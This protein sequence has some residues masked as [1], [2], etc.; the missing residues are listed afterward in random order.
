[1]PTSTT[2]TAFAVAALLLVAIP[3]P[4]MLFILGRGIS[5][6]RRAAFASA[7][8]V[9]L[10]TL[11]H[12]FAAAF[13]LSAVVAASATAFNIVRYAGVIYLLYLAYRA[14]P[15][16]SKASIGATSNAGAAISL[17]RTAREGALTN[18]LNPKVALFFLALLP[19]F[20]DPAAGSLVIQMLVLGLVF[21]AIALVMDL[22]YASMSVTVSAWLRGHSRSTYWQSVASSVSLVLLAGW[23]AMT[24]GPRRAGA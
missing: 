22:I 14:W 6:G 12:V 21:F 13:G 24:S 5:G 23:A 11:F 10:G 2:I 19:Q 1:M 4:N 18:I 17:I 3:G 20:T 7:V 8:G 9:E 15:R 16:A